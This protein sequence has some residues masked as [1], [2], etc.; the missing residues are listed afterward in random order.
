MVTY[1]KVHISILCLLI[2][3][4]L[5][6]LETKIFENQYQV[7]NKIGYL[8]DNTPIPNNYDALFVDPDPPECPTNLITARTKGR[9]GNIMGEYASVWGIGRTHRRAPV[10]PK[11][12]EVTLSKYFKHLTLPVLVHKSYPSNCKL[13][14]KGHWGNYDNGNIM[15]LDFEFVLKAFAPYKSEIIREF[16]FKDEIVAE[17]QGI[18][19]EAANGYQNNCTYVSVHVRRTDYGDWLKDHVNGHLV[20]PRYFYKAMKEMQSKFSN[21]LFIIISDD[22]PWCEKNIKFPDF[23]IAFLGNNNITNPIIDLAIISLTNHSI[24]THGTFGFWG[25]YLSNGDV[26]QPKGFSKNLPYPQ[27]SVKDAHLRG[28]TMIADDG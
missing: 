3:L 5:W 24:L 10:I 6:S 9:L 2:L 27:S 25:A 26:I 11:D 12:M 4:L 21:V 15:I 14:I 13:N 7:I 20:T 28:W 23:N 22:M 1:L 8:Y 17:A 19:N 18:I 16:Q